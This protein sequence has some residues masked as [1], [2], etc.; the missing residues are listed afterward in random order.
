MAVEEQ[1]LGLEVPVDDLVRD[2]VG[3]G[4]GVGVGVR[5]RIRVRVRVRVRV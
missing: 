1:V 5:I 2:W 3:A 4:V